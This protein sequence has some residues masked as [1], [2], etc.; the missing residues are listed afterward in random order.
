M[1]FIGANT[2]RRVEGSKSGAN[3]SRSTSSSSALSNSKATGNT[4]TTSSGRTGNMESLSITTATSYNDGGD[5]DCD[6]VL[7]R[8]N[9]LQRAQEGELSIYIHVYI[10]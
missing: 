4:T 7:H 1:D 3:L 2:A 9:A 5:D 6:D 8:V 10:I